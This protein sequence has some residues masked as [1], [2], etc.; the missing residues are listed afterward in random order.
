MVNFK[1]H[2]AGKVAAKPVDPVVLYGTLDREHDKGPLRPAQEAILA[3][4]HQNQSKARDVI[5][6][7]HTGQGKTL[8]GLLMLQSRLNAGKFPVVYL[9]PDNFLIN[10]TCEQAKQFG[11]RTCTSDDD[12]PEEFANGD[13]IL[14][15][16]A[17]K[18]FNGMTKFGL[19]RHS[20]QVDTVLMDDAH[21][22]ADRVREQCRIRIP[23]NEPAYARLMALFGTELEQQGAGTYAEIENAKRDA[24]LPV[25]YWSWL[26]HESEIASVLAQESARKSIKF[27]WPLLKDMLKHCQCIVSGAAIEIEPYV[28][29]L[30][31][32]GS[33]ARAAHRIFMSATV[34][35][36]AFLVKGLQLSPQTISNPLT[37]AKETWSGEKMIL[38]PSVIHEDLDRERLVKWLAT[39]ADKRKFGRVGLTPSVAR[40]KDW[41]SY[42]AI[43][44]D[45]TNVDDVIDGLRKGYYEKTV[46]LV[47]RYDGI[48]LP[49]STC[50]ILMFDSK[51]FSESLIDLYAERVRP[52]SKATLTKTMRTIEQGMGRSVRGE[53]DYS[54]IIVVGSELV[55]TLRDV[56]SRQ[57]LSPQFAKQIEIGIQ[58]GKMAKQEIAEGEAPA[59]A[60]NGLVKQC[61]SRD[62]DWKAYYVEQMASVVPAG[63][64]KVILDIYAAELKAEKAYMAGDYSAAA[65]IL[66]DLLDGGN[67]DAEDKGWYLQERARYFYSSARLDSQTQQQAAHKSNMLLLRPPTGVTVTKLTL[68]SQGRVE[69]VQ[70][71]IRNFDNYG[72]LDVTVSDILGR[73][74]F[75]VNADKF[76]HALNELSFA[77]GFVGERPDAEWKEGPDNLWALDDRN[78]LLIE[79]KSEVDVTRAE[80]NKREAEQMNRSS[81]WFEKHYPGFNAKRI[82]IHPAGK[83]E[84]AAAFTHDVEGM[85]EHHLKKL[86]KSCRAF[87]K[88]FEGLNF[89]DLSD[90]HTQKLIDLHDLSVSAILSSYSQRLKDL[91]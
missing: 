69:R 54:V 82:I 21:A 81:A 50:R 36:D 51:P 60:F 6:K 62:D 59:A 88:A 80:V 39:P 33:Y 34:T 22:C 43:I 15:T 49:D 71:W 27:A 14:V 78:Y 16:S 83:I 28:A 55:R 26:E 47:N 65:A 91:K 40:S 30:E 52:N 2:L 23:S 70:K 90:E 9:C 68:R 58:L 1:K 48:D 19:H 66:Q 56:T 45:K 3:A 20:I 63:A 64:N 37:Y 32:F 79:C 11:I 35:D 89:K 10:Q 57:Y 76:E 38:L 61:L 31:A 41:A 8:V 25:P 75:G 73:L 87:F 84:S 29:P 7:L 42:G 67:V 24:F 5:V 77:L 17:S 44:T 12:L 4:W 18:L 13:R 72:S 53:K 74:V 86:V 46:V 85:R